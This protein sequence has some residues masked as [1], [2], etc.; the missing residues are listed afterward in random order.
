MDARKASGEEVEA[1]SGAD[2]GGEDS[3]SESGVDESDDEEV[4]LFRRG[5][6]AAPKKLA[7]VAKKKGGK[8]PTTVTAS[9]LRSSAS[10]APTSP[11]PNSEG[12]SLRDDLSKRRGRPSKDAPPKGIVD[13]TGHMETCKNELE[14]DIQ[15]ARDQ[16]ADVLQFSSDDMATEITEIAKKHQASAN[17]GHGNQGEDREVQEVGTDCK[18]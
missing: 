8:A 12:Q 14:S 13:M 6:N 7:A 4:G 1:D 3:N 9:A 11:R 15:L 17:T 16:A 10:S 5:S 18:Y 2:G